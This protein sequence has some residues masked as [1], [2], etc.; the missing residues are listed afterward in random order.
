VIF[1]TSVEAISQ[2]LSSDYPK[3]VDT[4]EFQHIITG[5]APENDGYFYVNWQESEPILTK[6]LPIA[7]VVEFGVKPLLK[8]L[9]SFT[10]SSEGSEQGIRRA[11]IFFNVGV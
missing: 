8:N 9:R 10:L 6:K 4:E 3:L 1:S 7:R 5:L 2:A 11:T